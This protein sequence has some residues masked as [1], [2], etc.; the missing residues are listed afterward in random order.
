ML[1]R[2]RLFAPAAA[3]ALVFE[4]A[5][6]SAQIIS[7][8]GQVLP[9]RFVNGSDVGV[10]T[11]AQNLNP[12]GVSYDDCVQ[13]MVLQF[14]VTLSGFA[15]T[16]ASLQVWA[17][18][19]GDCTANTARGLGL[20]PTCWQLFESAGLNNTAVQTVQINL[21]VRDIV[22]PQDGVP[23]QASIANTQARG[24]Q[25]GLGACL[26]QPSFTPVQM[27]IWF[28][29][30]DSGG[31]SIGTP[32]EYGATGTPFL[33]DLVGPPAPTGV[34]EN[35]GDT[36]FN[37]FWTANGDSDTA[38][39]DVF[40]DPI[41]GQEGT[42]SATADASVLYCIEGGS[43]STAIDASAD[44]GDEGD[45]GDE[46]DVSADADDGAGDAEAGDADVA[47]TPGPDA[48]C[49]YINAGGPAPSGGSCNDPVLSGSIVQDAG[50]N[51][52]T[53]TTIFD[54]AGNAIDSGIFSGT[55]GISTVDPRY[56]T[57]QGPTG[58]TVSDKSTGSYTISGLKNGTTYNVVV[59]AVDGFGNVGPS[60]TEVCDSPAP[61][62]DFWKLY[63]E[64][65][66]RAGGG[67]CALEA[68]GEPVPASIAG[69]AIL[70]AATTL[71]MRR[72]RRRARS[73]G[74]SQRGVSQ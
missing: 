56:L 22:G 62:A 28:L 60:S 14:T 47:V 67:F 8:G 46:A 7:A 65:G 26:T 48:T 44:A 38:G 40:I 68:V 18:N 37:V 73:R 6:A 36:L 11:R 70:A 69:G 61:V 74:P 57:G 32:Y 41:P 43:S 45:G 71:A 35:V 12:A 30:V 23:T 31:N 66:G 29:A 2:S 58:V 24:S 13:N 1:C 53:T 50:T 55:G 49:F 52:T 9:E 33:A 3:L 19:Q 72:R 51:S 10:S 54:E 59:A 25:R 42:P 5:S 39:Y 15:G 16:N 4:S 64:A 34:T 27:Y 20:A 21:A 63:R 17:T